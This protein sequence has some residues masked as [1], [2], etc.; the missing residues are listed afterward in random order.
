MATY[1]EQFINNRMASQFLQL[2]IVDG[3]VEMGDFMTLIDPKDEHDPIYGVDIVVITCGKM[4]SAQARKGH[5]MSYGA[6]DIV[7][8]DITIKHNVFDFQNSYVELHPEQ[9][10]AVVTL[11]PTGGVQH[12]F[13]TAATEK[14][15]NVQTTSPLMRTCIN[16]G[17][18]VYAA[19]VQFESIRH[20]A[21]SPSQDIIEIQGDIDALSSFQR[22]LQR[23]KVEMDENI[24]TGTYVHGICAYVGALD[25]VPEIIGKMKDGIKGG[26]C[27]TRDDQFIGPIGVY[28]RGD[29]QFASPVDLYSWI[30]KSGERF[31]DATSKLCGT[32]E[33]LHFDDLLSEVV[34]SNSKVVGLWVDTRFLEAGGKELETAINKIASKFGVHVD[35]VTGGKK[36]YKRNDILTA[37]AEW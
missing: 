16:G 15:A 19:D 18:T 22:T 13:G 9:N 10:K 6:F 27:C 32:Q 37:I 25:Q 11:K 5:V 26:I 8:N 36:R 33:E 3:K 20:F 1:L 14:F 7:S 17:P 35:K 23:R 21:F 2:D 30:D 34:V 29:V 24:L 12:A 28:V 4:F 31:F